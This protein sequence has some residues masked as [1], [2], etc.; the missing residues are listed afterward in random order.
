MAIAQKRLIDRL[1]PAV[2]I[3]G[4][5]AL[6]VHQSIA[7]LLGDLSGTAGT[8]RKASVFAVDATNRCYDRSSAAGKRLDQ[9]APV[10]EPR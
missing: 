10:R 3:S 6:N 4:C 8:N 1:H 2:W 7:Q 9:S 5:T